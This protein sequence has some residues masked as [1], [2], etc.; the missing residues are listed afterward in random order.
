[1]SLNPV[2]THELVNACRSALKCAEQLPAVALTSANARI[3]ARKA[4]RYAEL[5]QQQLESIGASAPLVKN[6]AASVSEQQSARL[7]PN[8]ATPPSGTRGPPAA[9]AARTPGFRG[10]TQS[11]SLADLIGFI[12][13]LGHDGVLTITTA[14]ESVELIFEKGDLIHAESRNPPPGMRLGDI[15]VVRGLIS[16]AALERALSA[17]RG[18]GS[19][20]GQTLEGSLVTREDLR[21]ALEFQAQNLFQ[22]LFEYD[23]SYFSFTEG[24]PADVDRRIR[25]KVPQLVLDS[26]RSSPESVPLEPGSLEPAP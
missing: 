7:Q 1:M 8:P 20:L 23:N 17:A 14:K 12:S 11:I 21:D 13:L 5:C 22:R 19:K 9:G 4:Q 24:L 16:A 26:V 10:Y 6:L 2:S 18:R 3:S 25:L 15:L